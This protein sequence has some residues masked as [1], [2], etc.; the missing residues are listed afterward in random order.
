MMIIYAKDEDNGHLIMI[1]SN[2]YLHPDFVIR[3]CS[4][5]VVFISLL[6]P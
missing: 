3:D 2:N 5:K 6:N 4:N 1:K